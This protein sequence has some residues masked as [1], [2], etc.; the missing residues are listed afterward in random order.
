VWWP[1]SPVGAVAVGVR[2]PPLLSPTRSLTRSPLPPVVGGGRR[3]VQVDREH[4]LKPQNQCRL[5]SLRWHESA[6]WPWWFCSGSP[7]VLQRSCGANQDYI[8]S[9]SAAGGINAHARL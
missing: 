5:S 1:P 6:A 4:E 3:A 7:D 8:A 9:P 2:R